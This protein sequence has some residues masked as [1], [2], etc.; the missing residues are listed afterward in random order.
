[1]PVETAVGLEAGLIGDLFKL[2]GAEVLE[3]LG[4]AQVVLQRILAIVGV[5]EAMSGYWE[6]GYGYVD[7]HDSKDNLSYHNASAAFTRR[8]WDRISNSVRVIANFGQDPGAGQTQTADGYLFLIENSLISSKP[9]TLVPYMN[10]WAGF[11]RP[12]SLARAAGAGGVLLNTG[13]NFETDGI[14]G[15]P[16]MDDTGHNTYG[17]ALGIEYL[18]DLTQQVVFEF[19]ALDAFDQPGTAADKAPEYGLG[20]RYQRNLSNAWIFR[21]DVINV[22]RD[23]NPDVTGVRFEVRR[24]F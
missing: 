13:I 16:A 2:C 22:F 20:A 8:Y 15:F 4:F 17:G 11:D 24:K 1:M 7:G 18:F 14:T 23:N 3:I 12:Q 5:I 9:L 19:A 6:A 21:T 10:V